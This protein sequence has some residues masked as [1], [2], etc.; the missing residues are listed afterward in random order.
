M[1]AS[2]SKNSLSYA[3]RVMKESQTSPAGGSEDVPPFAALRMRVVPLR[4]PITK[5][6]AIYFIN[7]LLYLAAESPR[8]P[9]LMEVS[10]PG[11]LVAQSVEILRIMDNLS[12]PISTIAR[13]TVGGTAIVLAAH[14]LRGFR[15]ALPNCKFSA[16][17]DLSA[18]GEGDSSA[19]EPWPSKLSEMIAKDAGKGSER[20]LS[21]LASG[22]EFT[23]AQ[24]LEAGLIDFIS[25]TA[26][27]PKT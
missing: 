11:G 10:S 7:R 21:W 1:G 5:R 2:L 19:N 24:A 25:A 9:I 4:G 14:G 20:V 22:A 13:G 16:A 26:K 3:T 8:E 6:S 18:G 12:C 23:A 27:V 17:L 15:T